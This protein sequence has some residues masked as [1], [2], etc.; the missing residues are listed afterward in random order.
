MRKKSSIARSKPSRQSP[1]ASKGNSTYSAINN[2]SDDSKNSQPYTRGTSPLTAVISES[3][4]ASNNKRQDLH[5]DQNSSNQDLIPTPTS[6]SSKSSYDSN[7]IIPRDLHPQNNENLH[8]IQQKQSNNHNQEE[9]DNEDELEIESL[10]RYNI[11]PQLLEKL[12]TFPLFRNAPRT[13][14]KAIAGRLKLVQHHP[15]EYIVKFGEPAKSMYLIL[16]GS[17]AV[18][19]PD[20]EA[21]HAELVSGQFFGEIGILF[22]RPRTATVIAKTKV[23][24]GVLTAD[25]FNSVLPDF[26][27]VER[28]IRD[29]AQERLSMQDKRFRNGVTNI[30]FKSNSL[31]SSISNASGRVLINEN[32]QNNTRSSVIATANASIPG[33]SIPPHT[34]SEPSALAQI[35]SSLL[36]NVSQN[37]RKSSMVINNQTRK[38]LPKIH[39]NVDNSIPTRDFLRS[40]PMFTLLPSNIIHELVLGVEPQ[41]FEPFET[42]VK[43]GEQAR[44]IYF[45]VNGEVEVLSP[46]RISLASSKGDQDKK[47]DRVL[48]RLGTGQY[49]GEMAFLQSI[50]PSDDDLSPEQL[51]SERT[52]DIRSVSTVDVLIVSG[53]QLENL[54]S[55]YP[56]ICD[57]MRDTA[58]KRNDRNQITSDHDSAKSFKP[59]NDWNLLKDSPFSKWKGFASTNTDRKASTELHEPVPKRR[60]SNSYVQSSNSLLTFDVSPSASPSPPSKRTKNIA[61]TSDPIFKQPKFTEPDIPKR[62][63]SPLQDQSPSSSSSQPSS[64][65]TAL[66]D[67]ALQS[68]FSTGPSSTFSKP[69]MFND[70]FEFQRRKSIATISQTVDPLKDSSS[71]SPLTLSVPPLNPVLPSINQFPSSQKSSQPFQYMNHAKRVR[72]QNIGGRRRSSVLSTGPLPDRILLNIFKLLPLPDLMKLRIICRRWRQLLYVA[73]GFFET[74]DLKPYNISIDDKALIQIIDFVGSRPRI[75]DISDCFHITDVGFCY[76]VNEI[77]MSGFIQTIKMR[78]VWEVSAMAIMDV[79]VPSIGHHIIELDL[80]NCRKVRDDVV[81]RLIGWKNKP[82]VSASQQQQS[83]SNGYALEGPVPGMEEFDN[84]EASIGCANLKILNLG[85]CKHLTDRSMYHIALHAND[86]IESLDLT[87]CTTIT[88]AGFAYWAYQPFPNLRKLKLSDCTFL[89]DK[90]I[91]AITSSAQGLH[92][93]DLSF[94][95]AL[96]DVS[97][98][99]LCLGCPGLKHLDL[100][101]CGSAISDSSL[102]AISLHLRQLESLVIK[103]CVRVT[104][105]GVDALLSSSLPL[106]YLDISQCR[107]AHYYGGQIPA[108]KINPN[109]NS[110]SA[111]VTTSYD[112]VVEIVI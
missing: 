16:R 71:S 24:L 54:Y 52:A 17:V 102:L 89:S 23:L 29:E 26:P 34:K 79:A 74:L 35:P 40:L 47:V 83:V 31:T 39:D 107:N 10:T 1:L 93:L 36:D 2:T 112:R 33:P 13:F 8:T 84:H 108:P 75:I 92:S 20:G 106:R 41:R 103:G 57:E 60:R 96:T 51:K 59:E 53:D 7:N 42:I 22:N 69:S 9:I 87:R 94:C 80:S 77:G 18:T 78:S 61:I 72:L 6:L 19:S 44:D 3:D 45:I 68:S 63:K 62:A 82:G 73:P 46:K 76:M 97:V 12:T 81:E 56:R 48:A 86:R 21:V 28:M 5:C 88:D 49:F 38:S 14:H 50:T 85:Y 98:E 30:N 15:Q 4:F 91:I 64:S 90:S 110:K 104:R 105:A 111:Y 65:M 25:N 37:L 67:S 32:D 109:P 55:R 11:P 27:I 101:F 70:K 58:K 66:L 43:K 95:C 100:S 99:V